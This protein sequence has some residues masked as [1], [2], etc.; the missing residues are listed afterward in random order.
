MK[1]NYK[2]F[3]QHSIESIGGKQVSAQQ[4]DDQA[5]ISFSI[6]LHEKKFNVIIILGEMEDIVLVQISCTLPSSYREPDI[7]FY[8]I[9]EKLNM[10]CVMGHI[11]FTN[12]NDNYFIAY[13]SNYICD[14]ENFSANTS[15]TN[16]LSASIDMIAVFDNELNV[17]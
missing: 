14:I 13:K 11:F 4:I 8:K 12:E 9:L 10:N 2:T 17:M 7:K 1:E 15:F 5:T 3:I 6:D 16:Y